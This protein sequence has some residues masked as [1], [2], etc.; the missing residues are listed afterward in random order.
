MITKSF[1]V[2]PGTIVK[3]LGNDT[4]HYGVVFDRYNSV[5]LIAFKDERSQKIVCK[6]IAINL[7]TVEYHPVT[8]KPPVYNIHQE[9][10]ALTTAQIKERVKTVRPK[11]DGTEYHII[12]NNCQ[13]F[14]YEVSTGIRM[15]PD[16]DSFKPLGGLINMAFK[17][18]DFGVDILGSSTSSSS[19]ASLQKFQSD[20]EYLIF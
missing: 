13:H 18:K 15:S 11:Y 2:P 6:V 14:A 17:L 1:D 20:L 9:I 7:N 5:E 8:Q 16:A 12:N 4:P 3:L 19:V 10:S